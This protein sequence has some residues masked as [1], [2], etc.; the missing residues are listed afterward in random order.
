MIAFRQSSVGGVSIAR[1]NLKNSMNMKMDKKI[2]EVL[3]TKKHT[4]CVQCAREMLHSYVNNEN[5]YAAPFCN[6]PECPNYGLL[7]TGILPGNEI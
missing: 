3:E 5:T 2:D 7:Q 1:N 4:R 6:Y